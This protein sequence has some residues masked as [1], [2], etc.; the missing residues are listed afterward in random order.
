MDL[1][2]IDSMLDN[3]D[4]LVELQELYEAVF[5]S[6]PWGIVVIDDD[7]KVVLSNA[8]FNRLLGYE[9]T[10]E[11]V[12]RVA[13]KGPDGGRVKLKTK[14]GKVESTVT[15]HPVTMGDRQFD[16]WHVRV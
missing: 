12:S 14:R 7:H 8:A 6:V 4:R 16:A 10:G 13:A 5:S 11:N 2:K 3:V 9:P 15:V 1:D